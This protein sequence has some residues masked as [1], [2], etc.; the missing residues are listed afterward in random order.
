[1]SEC[2]CVW[3]GVVCIY[4]IVTPHIEDLLGWGC[5]G[6]KPFEDRDFAAGISVNRCL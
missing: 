1:M 3:C 6:I 4:N 2:V 5:G